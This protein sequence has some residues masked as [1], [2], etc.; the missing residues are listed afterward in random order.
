MKHDQSCT[1]SRSESFK[2]NL[3]SE[4]RGHLFPAGDY[5]ISVIT[6]HVFSMIII[7]NWFDF[8]SAFPDCQSSI[9]SKGWN[10]PYLTFCARKLT[11]H[12]AHHTSVGVK[13]E[14]WGYYLKVS[15]KNPDLFRL[16]KNQGECCCIKYHSRFQEGRCCQSLRQW[17]WPEWLPLCSRSQGSR[18]PWAGPDLLDNMFRNEYIIN[19]MSVYAIESFASSD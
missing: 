19:C 11:T 16:I 13:R 18:V 8:Y 1:S 17:V 12:Q 7:H 5:H 9:V 10:S 6:L 15:S 4:H 3:H 14:M 2:H